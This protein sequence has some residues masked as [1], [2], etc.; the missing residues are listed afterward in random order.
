MQ[1]P[2]KRL[3]NGGRGITGRQ[4][5]GLPTRR[6]SGESAPDRTPH[7]LRSLRVGHRCQG[8]R[9]AQPV[10]SVPPRV[11]AQHATGR[12]GR[13]SRHRRLHRVWPTSPMGRAQ[14]A[15]G[16]SLVALAG[17]SR[18]RPVVLGRLPPPGEQ[19]AGRRT[20]LPAL[21][22]RV[23]AQPAQRLVLHVRLPDGRVA[24]VAPAVLTSTPGSRCMAGSGR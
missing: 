5:V 10:A 3:R 6:T 2:P 21:R 19:H 20:D 14:Q 15:P 4:Q 24:S 16:V 12:V 7:R 9:G 22:S 13:D 17:A 18:P 8:R 11:R 1:V 23:L